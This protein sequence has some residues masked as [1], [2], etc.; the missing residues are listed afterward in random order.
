MRDLTILI[1]TVMT[2]TGLL[3][4]KF[5]KYK[6]SKNGG[7]YTRPPNMSIETQKEIEKIETDFKAET[8]KLRKDKRETETCTEMHSSVKVLHKSLHQGMTD[9]LTRIEDDVGEI[10][11][12]MGEI[13]GGIQSL[14]QR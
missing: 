1:S 12:D 5:V 11:G 13:K 3:V 4:F 7:S 14:L 10:K 6:F 9:R 8:A 2:G